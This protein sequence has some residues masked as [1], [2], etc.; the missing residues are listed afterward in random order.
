M[1]ALTPTANWQPIRQLTIND[2]NFASVFNEQNQ[3]VLDRG[4]SI[5]ALLTELEQ[6]QRLVRE[7]SEQL[8]A[9]N[10]ILEARQGQLA[11]VA[12]AAENL[13]LS[14]RFAATSAGFSS[15]FAAKVQAETQV[16][17]LEDDTKNLAIGSKV[18]ARSALLSELETLTLVN[19]RN[20]TINPANGYGWANYV[21]VRSR[22]TVSLFQE[23]QP[24]GQ[25]AGSLQSPNSWE[26]RSLNTIK[27]L[28]I[29][30]SNLTQRRIE[31]PPGNYVILAFA[32]VAGCDRARL[33]LL[34]GGSPIAVGASGNVASDGGSVGSTTSFLLPLFCA[35]SSA[36]PLELS[37][38][39]IGARNHGS[40]PTMSEG[41][42]ANLTSTEIYSQILVL[43]LNPS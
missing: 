27:S 16:N 7:K 26:S 30:G 1:T 19:D 24:Q 9:L 39:I 14:N 3:D 23:A 2:F 41:R 13:A 5:R 33:G 12:L 10:N 42:A 28:L 18:Q 6:K 20:L 40:A 17:D 32:T 35:L 25:N 15:T 4:E 37:L 21:G 36:T 22:P 11:S 8:K 29:E 43:A 38:G 31:L 34:S